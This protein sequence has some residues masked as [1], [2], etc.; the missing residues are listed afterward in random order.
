MQSS[1]SIW[2]S[3]EFRS[4]LGTT[5]FSGMALAMQQLLVSWILIGILLLPA[6]QVGFI[7]ALIGIPG[8][9]VM[10]I[11]GASADRVDARLLLIKVYLVAPVLPLYLVYIEQSGSLSV[12]TVTLFGLGMG[13]V[14]SYSM[15]AQQALLNRVSGSQVQEAVTAASAI[16]FVVQIVGL[17]IAGQMEII[18][19]SPVLV[20][21]AAS[22]WLAGALMFRITKLKSLEIKRSSSA[23]QEIWA[24]LAATY[25]D[26]VILNVLSINFV[27]SIFN[28]GAFMTVYPFII[29]RVY[30]GNAITLAILMSIFF[31]GAAVSN[32][33][34][35]KFMP[36][37]FPGRLFLVMQLSRIVVLFLLWLEPSWWLLVLATIGW[38]L[39]M[40]VT[41]NLARAVVQES[42]EEAYRGRIMSA[43][44][45][46]MLGSAPIGAILLGWLTENYGTANALV[47]AMFVSLGLFFYGARF[48]SVWSYQGKLV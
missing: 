16:G 46:G 13:V 33:L 12:L 10:L 45:I 47:P 44:S 11:G 43:F 26:K 15:P 41:T 7:Q 24:G 2:Q 23:A 29:K 38:G 25:R 3:S 4:Y 20:F 35:L 9:L 40:G 32:A 21:Q 19:V 39:N 42:A 36:L 31:A 18:G 48:T 37:R 17:I 6:D 8:I 1:E 28:A 5:G 30:E 14:S 27:S 34:L 22:L